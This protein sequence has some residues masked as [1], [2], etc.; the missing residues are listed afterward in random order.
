MKVPVSPV[1]IA[2]LSI[3][4]SALAG[5][6]PGSALN[7]S[8]G[9]TTRV[10][11]ERGMSHLLSTRLRSPAGFLYPDPLV[12]DRLSDLAGSWLYRGSLEFGGLWTVGNDEETRFTEF[13]DWSEGAFLEFFDFTVEQPESGF[14]ADLNGGSAGRDDQYYYGK[15]GVP[16]LFHLE[17]SFSG[18]PHVFAGDVTNIY[19]GSG[20]GVLELPAPLVPGDNSDAEIVDVLEI[21]PESRLKLQRDRSQFSLEFRPVDAL[22]LFARYSFDDRSGERPFGGSL[23]FDSGGEP[24]RVV[25]TTEP[26]NHHTDNFTGGASFRSSVVLANLEYNGS[27]FRNQ[28]STLTWDNPFLTASFNGAQNVE[29]GR[30]ALAPDNHWHNVKGD[31]SVRLPWD[32][33]LSTT[34]SWS[35]ARQDDDLITPTVNSGFVGFSGFNGVNLDEWNTAAALPR[36]HADAQLDTLLLN[37]RLHLRPLDALRLQAGIRYYNQQNDTRYTAQNPSTGQFGYIAEDGALN[38]FDISR[39]FVPGVETDDFRYRSSPFDYRKLD[40]EISA[41]YQPLGRTTLGGRYRREE[42][43]RDERERD[44]TRENQARVSLTSRD[45]R[46]AT[47]RASYEYRDREGGPYD[48]FPNRDDYVSSL[49]GYVPFLEFLGGETPPF[50]LAQLRKYDLADRERHEAKLSANFLPRDDLDL[51]ITTRFVDQDYGASYGLDLERS[52]NVDLELDYQPSPVVQTYVFGHF[53]MSRRQLANI[54]DSF[55]FPPSSDP[56]AGGPV[57]PLDNAWKLD[58]DEVSWGVGTGIRFQAASRVILDVNYLFIHTEE[59]YDFDIAGPGALDTDLTEA[60]D[61]PDLR[62]QN[63]L[64]QASIRYSIVESASLRFFYRF[65]RSTIRDFSQ[66]DLVPEEVLLSTGALFLGHIDRDYDVHVFGLTLQIR[67]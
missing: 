19:E 3:A 35:R 46:W 10:T 24:E 36:S 26:R 47:L 66:R 62:T 55:V 38:A 4:G 59:E 60:Q 15:I 30:F 39:V 5:S 17:G 18:I 56:N 31:I 13:A 29:R 37:A 14:Y 48:S 40:Y 64:L 16:G 54:N 51:S 25:E 57:F 63:H 27:L 9:D 42:I 49:P 58:T 6:A 23:I 50:T 44:K 53:E 12:P 65:E 33:R 7:P 2:L 11:D 20:S 41:D 43:D 32:G 28:D 45:V 22:S 67:L 34:A 52:G 1:V 61:L 8:G 21:T